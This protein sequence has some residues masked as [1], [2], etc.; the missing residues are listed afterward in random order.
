MR[1]VRIFESLDKKRRLTISERDDG[2]FTWVEEFENTEDM[3]GYGQGVSVFWCPTEWQGV[4]GSVDDAER[5]AR[6][7]TPWMEHS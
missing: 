7:V 1:I 2:H 6:A 4:Y 3:T 5:E